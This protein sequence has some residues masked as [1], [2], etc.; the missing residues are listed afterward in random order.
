MLRR[1]STGLLAISALVTISSIAI[2]APPPSP[3][4]IVFG[5]ATQSDYQFRGITQS[6]PSPWSGFYIG[7][8]V[9]YGWTNADV[10]GLST[11]G[12]SPVFGFSAGYRDA[13]QGGTLW[14]AFNFSDEI[15]TRAATFPPPLFDLT[16][17]PVNIASFT[18]QIG[19]NFRSGSGQWSPYIEAGVSLGTLK[20]GTDLGSD[21][22]TKVGWTI[23]AGMDYRINQNWLA[24]SEYKYT[25]FGREDFR[26]SPGA[27]YDVKADVHRA[28]VGL[29]WQP[30]GMAPPPPPP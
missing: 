29:I 14:N 4:D 12:S 30:W 16:I 23:G 28:L 10:P 27:V 19:P 17:K 20:V 18:Y 13:L 24:H 26:P 5:P 9:G 7:A 6:A 1:F 22:R 15:Y 2:A 21:T 8:N 3:W 11:S 25:S